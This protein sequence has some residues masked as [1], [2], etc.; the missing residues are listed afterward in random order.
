MQKGRA[1]VGLMFVQ[2]IFVSQL[3]SIV[4]LVEISIRSFL[5]DFSCV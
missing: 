4:F 3:I 1:F 2:I 5:V